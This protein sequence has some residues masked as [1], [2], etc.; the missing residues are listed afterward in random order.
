MIG[1]IKQSV[2]FKKHFDWPDAVIQVPYD[3][4]DIAKVLTDLDSQPERLEN[5]RKNNVVQSLLRHDWVYRWK[6]ILDM[7]GLEP[8][9]AFLIREARLK[10]LAEEIKKTS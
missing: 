1:E 6:T 5:I 8:R 3:T 7:V 9:P 10:N 2:A 4:A